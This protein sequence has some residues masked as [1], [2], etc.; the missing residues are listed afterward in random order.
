M[1]NHKNIGFLSNTGRDPLK[2]QQA[3]KP[4][5]NVGPSSAHLFRWW[6]GDCP[7][8][9]VF[10]SSHQLKNKKKIVKAGPPTKFSGSAHDT[11]CMQEEKALMRI[12][13]VSSEPSL[14]TN[15]IS[16]KI[17]CVGPYTLY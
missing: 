9:V 3:S 10:E 15:A 17:L 12:C 5:F 7:L 16:T 1:K 6:A 13:A 14:L 8:I 4:V 2:N 11:L